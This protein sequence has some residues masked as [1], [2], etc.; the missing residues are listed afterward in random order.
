MKIENVVAACH[1]KGIPRVFINLNAATNCSC[2]H[3]QA[4]NILSV[5]F[6]NMAQHFKLQE[7]GTVH[8]GVFTAA[9]RNI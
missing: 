8:L 4:H 7:R 9:I 2:G 6:Y 1:R 3:R 5:H